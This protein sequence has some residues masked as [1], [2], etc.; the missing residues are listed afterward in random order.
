MK[1]TDP[2]LEAQVAAYL[3]GQLGD[4]GWNALREKLTR[5]REA[6]DYFRAMV[7]LQ[8]GLLGDPQLAGSV[9]A[10][11][12]AATND[13]VTPHRFAFRPP[14]GLLAAAACLA[15]CAFLGWVFFPGA[16]FATVDS[17]LGNQTLAPGM[18]LRGEPRRL[19]AGLLEMTTAR[20][21]RVVI[22]APASFHFESAQVLRMEY[23]RVAADVPESAHGFT[24]LTPTGRAIDLGTSFGVD[25]PREGKAEI[26]V[27]EGEV[28]AQSAGGAKRNLYQGDAFTLQK[29][30]GA[31][32]ELRSSAFIRSDEMAALHAGAANDQQTRSDA[33]LDELRRDPSLIALLDFEAD[34][35]SAGIYRIAQGRWPGTRAPEFVNIDDHL[36]LDAGGERE[37]TQLTLAA[38]VR[39]DR[40]GAPYQSLL[41]TDGWNGNNPG[42][43]H[44]MVT[45][46]NTMR[47]A[48]FGNSL[49]EPRPEGIPPFPES[50][51]SVLPE[52]GRWV[53]LAAVYDSEEHS[54]RFYF[55]GRFDNETRLSIAHPA[56]LG[57][58]RIGNWDQKDRK[59]SGRID[60]LILL[61]R[62]MGDSEITALFEAGN[63]YR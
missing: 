44:W 45:N 42:Q 59:L 32:R 60:E 5:D 43:V 46:F 13:I 50:R 2:D 9:L 52:Q 23:G 28:I 57:P 41:H 63:P 51:T 47:L 12:D 14:P 35:L 3:D 36:I 62:T 16:P 40:L 31:T 61:G 39:L 58:A 22:E 20:G 4:E 19:Q 26:H 7:D 33:A 29:G 34:D 49:A 21:A 15:L 56:R 10:N 11:Q 30:A 38:W 54:V 37:L 53:H 27:F 24:V 18:V 55:N 6:R 1:V 17:S 48:L 8:A 25:V